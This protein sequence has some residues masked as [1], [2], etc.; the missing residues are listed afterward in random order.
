MPV[1]LRLKAPLGVWD[2][3]KNMD[4]KETL[5]TL[6]LN[7][8]PLQ[9]AIFKDSLEEFGIQCFVTGGNDGYGGRGFTY[10]AHGAGRY[11]I[12]VRKSDEELAIKIMTSLGFPV[13]NEDAEEQ[14]FLR[15]LA[16]PTER[17]PFLGERSLNTRLV[18]MGIAIT[19][20]ITAL[21]LAFMKKG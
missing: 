18:V 3:R 4:D 21:I 1:G 13:I 9:V 6:A 19:A 14:K 20:V 7:V 2:K 15:A 5:V 17:I 8:E 10:M 16:S 11:I 12:K